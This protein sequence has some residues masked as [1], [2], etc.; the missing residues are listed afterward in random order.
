MIR[1]RYWPLVL[2]LLSPAAGATTLDLNVNDD[3]ARLTLIWPLPGDS[4]L[5]LDGGWLHDQDRGDVAHVGVHLTGAASAEPNPVLGGLGVRLAYLDADGSS[6]TGTA[7]GIGGFLRYALP[8][9]NRINLGAHLYFAPDVL[10]FGDADQYREVGLRIGYNFLRDAD[11][12]LGYRNVKGK[13]DDF[14]DVTFDTGLHLGV[15]LSF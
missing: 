3:A 1:A 14:P 5:E 9:Y 7:L 15:R 13:F 2:L 11:V 12:Y 10:S 8:N 6:A 4:I